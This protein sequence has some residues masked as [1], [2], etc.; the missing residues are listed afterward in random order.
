M[1]IKYIIVS[2]SMVLLLPQCTNTSKSAT[3]TAKARIEIDDLFVDGEPEEGLDNIAIFTPATETTHILWK[4]LSGELSE[5]F[6]IRTV[7]TSHTT[8][9]S[10]IGKHIRNI[11]PVA[12]VLIDNSTVKKF[13][14]YQAYHK[15]D[16]TPVFIF[17]ASFLKEI[18]GMVNHAT[19]I[20]YEVPGVLSMVR[21]RN[22]LKTDVINVGAVYREAFRDY[23]KAEASMMSVEKFKMC[24]ASLGDNPTKFDLEA[25]LDNLLNKQKVDVLWI[26]NDNALLKQELVADVWLPT[27]HN[28]P[29]PTVVNVPVLL[30]PDVEFGTLAVI[31][32]SAALGVQAANMIFNA[33]DMD[34]EI[35]EN[36]VELPLS[37]LTY[38]DK[39]N[40]QK[41][42]GLRRNATD[43]IDK[44]L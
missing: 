26:L 11:K 13:R 33:Y 28:S 43:Y 3:S 18:I 4:S 16:K 5:E 31:P 6:N 23:V 39:E 35:E 34:W 38:I 36:R 15:N 14:K 41:N 19:G 25:A 10:D 9:A 8:S 2:L 44:Q 21:A 42:F 30:N 17:M 32:D 37:V 29:M 1:A 12:I 22:I 20:A 7:V 27:L 24:T 40:A